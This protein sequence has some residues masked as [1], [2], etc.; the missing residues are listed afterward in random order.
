ML[1]YHRICLTEAIDPAKCNNSKECMVSHY[2]YFN[3]ESKFQKL[4]L[5]WLP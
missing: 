3:N 2:W 1:Y 5:Q 4:C